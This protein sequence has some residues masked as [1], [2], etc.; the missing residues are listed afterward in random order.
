MSTLSHAKITPR[1]S[2]ARGHANHGWLNT[3]HTFSFASYFD[4][5]YQSFGPRRT[6]I[7]LPN[8]PH[9][10]AEIF[11]YILSGELTHR[12]SMHGKGA[13]KG[14]K[15]V[16][17][18]DFFVM[19]RGR[20][21]RPRRKKKAAEPA[22]RGTIPVHADLVMG[23]AIVGAGGAAT[24]RVGGGG[25][26]KGVVRSLRDRKVYVHLPMRG[27]K[28]KVRLAGQEGYVLGEG[29]GA[30]VEKVNVGDELLVESV[31]EGEAEVVVLDSN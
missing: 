30:F 22:V 15:E 21:S 23:A 3:Y 13:A 19:K 26:G 16:S 14:L 11:S 1:P 27:L 25:E 8:A 4:A 20:A 12:D 18:D 5:R 24:W 2:S 9:R 29:D 10:D 28:A 7:R 17:K 6:T 31:G